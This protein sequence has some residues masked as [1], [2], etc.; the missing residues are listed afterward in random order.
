MNND[1]IFEIFGYIGA[2]C[3]SIMGI[4]QV[5]HTVKTEKT[6]DI[7]I[8]FVIFNLLAICFLLPYSI[9]FKLYPIMGIP[10]VIHTIKTEKTE[11]ISIK[12]IV[13]NLLAI[14]F[15]LPYSIYFKL[16]PVMGANFSVC[17]CNLIILY[18][19]IRNQLK[20]KT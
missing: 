7:S 18:Y 13:F 17:I 2:F 19:C 14:C 9:Y 16:Y 6:E 20:N 5:I 4:P 3:L 1:N 8:K 15:L 10:Q 11:D 12:F